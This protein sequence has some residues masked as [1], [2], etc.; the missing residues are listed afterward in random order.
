M[1]CGSL[2]GLLALA[3]NRV[4]RRLR[5]PATAAALFLVLA[6]A[7]VTGVAY[8]AITAVQGNDAGANAIAQTI[9]AN[10]L[11]VSGSFFLVPTQEPGPNGVADE[12]LGGFPTEG[13]TFGILTTG[14][15]TLADD[16]NNAPNS[17]VSLGGGSRTETG[18][19]RDVTILKLDFT[20][21]EGSNCVGFDFKFLSEEYPEFVGV[22]F[23]DAFIAELDVSNWSTEGSQ[24]TAP[25]NFAFDPAGNPITVNATGS[26]SVSPANA[27]G[28]TYDAATA[29]LRAS[30]QLTPGPHSLFLSIFDQGDDVFDSAVF[31]DNLV[32]GFVP[33]PETE[34][35]AGAQQ[36]A[37]ATIE[38]TSDQDTVIAG[39]Q[40]VPVSGISLSELTAPGDG[41]AQSTPLDG[42]PLDGIDLALSPLDGIPL[43]GIGL[44]PQL[45]QQVLG[46]VHLS[47]I[48]LSTAGGWDAVL[49]GTSLDGVPLNT[50]TLADVYALANPPTNDIS[51]GEID[52]SATPLD[53]IPLAGL[54]L[55]PRLLSE[56]PLD[57]SGPNDAAENLADWCEQMNAEPGHPCSAPS[58]LQ[59]E[60]LIGATVK[61]LPLDGIPLDGIPLDGIPLDGIPLDGIPLDGIDLTGT[62][63]DGIP[64][65]GIDFAVSPLDG[66]PLD[67]I[68]ITGSPLDGIPLDGISPATRD[69]VVDCTSPGF[70][71]SGKTLGQAKVAGR[72]LPGANLGML[73]GAFGN[74]TLGELIDALLGSFGLS[75]ADL[76]KGLPEPPERTLHDLLAVLL[77]TAGYDWSDLDL[78]A[79]PIALHSP[80][81]G[82]ISYRATFE[83]TGGASPTVATI[84]ASLPEGGLYG[85][86]STRLIVVGSETSVPLGEPTVGAS[87]L[88]WTP[89][90]DEGTQYELSWQVHA[91]IELGNY[92]ISA[93]VFVTGM[94]A[95]EGSD[96]VSVDVTQ[97]LEPNNTPGVG[98][99]L[100][101]NTLYLSYMLQGDVDRYVVPIP[102]EFGSRVKITLSHITEGTDLDLTVSGPPASVL[103]AAPANSIPLQNTQL[104]DAKVELDE[105]SQALAPE[106]LQDVPTDAITTGPNVVRASSDNRGSADE[107][108]TLISQGESGQYI[109]QVS[110]YQ[111]DS[112]LP[113]MLE[114][115]VSGP[116]NLGNCA[117]RSFPNAGQGAAGAIPNVPA[118]VNTLILV[119]RKRLGDT[120]GAAA[121]NDVMAKLNEL[122][123]RADLGIVGAV[124]PVD[125]DPGVAAAYNAWDANPCSPETANGVVREIGQLIDT[126]EPA[127]LRYKVI[128]GGDDQIPFARVP[129]ETLIANESSYVE[130]LTGP[131]NQYKGAFGY[132][133]LMTDDVYAEEAAP[134]LFGHELFVPEQAVGRVLETPGEITGMIDAFLGADGAA[135]PQRSLVTGYDFLTDGSNAVNAPFATAFGAN[136]QTLINESW[137]AKDPASGDIANDLEDALFPP[138]NAPQLNSINAHFDHT[139]L[140]PAAENAANLSAN[141]YVSQDV[142]DRGAAAVAERV[143]FSMGCHSGLSI[144]DV[145][146]GNGDPLAKDWAQT[147]LAGGA[148][149]WIGNTGYGLGD[150]VEVAYTERLHALFSGN[151]DGSLTLGE[152]LA[153]AKQEY[154]SQL[155]IIGGYD[156]KVVMQATLFGLP[157]LK[158]GTGEPP[159]DPEPLPTQTDPA[160]GLEAAPFNVNPTFTLVNTPDGRFYR[161]QTTQTTNRRP[162]EPAL[163]FDVTQPGKVAH[164]IV[165]T[166]LQS[167]ADEENFDAAFSRVVTDKSED[168]PELVGE[169][170]YP[171]KIQSL[172][173]FSSFASPSVTR[174]NA[175]LIAGL[176]R[177]DGVPDPLGVGTHRLYNQIGG[178][179]LY[180]A[181]GETDFTAP[182]LGPLETLTI[183][184][185]VGFA[186]SV[187]DAAGTVEDVKVIY[188]DCVGTW[189]LSTLQPS[190]ENR[191]S[192]G[193]AIAPSGCNQID[194]YL[195][196]VDDAGNVAVSS[197]KVQI[198]PVVLPPPTGE[199][200]IDISLSGSSHPSG[201]HTGPVSVTITATPAS[202]VEFSLDGAAFQTYAGAFTVGGDGVHIVEARAEDGSTATAGFAIDT[203]APVVLMTTPPAGAVYE[204]GQVVKAEFTC[205]DAGSGPASCTGTVANGAPLATGTVGTKTI[206]VTATDVVGRTFTLTRT[207]QVVYAF[208]GFFD[209]VMNPPALNVQ[210]AGSVIPMKFSLGGN[211]G[212]NIFA[213][214]FPRSQQINCTTKALMG[215]PASTVAQPPG[216][217]YIASSDSYEYLWKTDAK[218]KGT[219]RAFLLGLKDG[220]S[221]RADFRLN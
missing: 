93:N 201:W 199:T 65:D 74:I 75:L 110:D 136:A 154:L 37:S 98:P 58:S 33:N 103:R 190:G 130:T 90:V 150:T 8:A 54:A 204:L 203:T 78:K 113:Y 11:E 188:R 155:G 39:A 23:N 71:C 192:G 45:L 73:D 147:F 145:I 112:A 127:D 109:V 77:G 97:T 216:L 205:A 19:D 42:I 119:N 115:E 82:V 70:D 208:Q 161:A 153:Q 206:S 139:R 86:E 171:A 187:T 178:H 165:I 180:A 218:W 53:G 100:K 162:I 102:S 211:Q 96:P 89:E 88:E 124:V 60:T 184:S 36:A 105:R 29:V 219:C 80:D 21:P 16:P 164:G 84:H 32:V 172:S 129:D 151:L 213:N 24:I 57:Q 17:G 111:G 69:Q 79:F 81:G 52:L 51:L 104:S 186:V 91:P 46:G 193:G 12:P 27:A 200:E 143:L 18:S 144:S 44:T 194:Y 38:L 62:P 25:N 101:A 68:D 117:P 56:I 128:V 183:G 72:L 166:S 209:P 14:D 116:P 5:L 61:G 34:C 123:G 179:V 121:M 67:G 31:L 197:K 107:E 120:Y 3:V 66:I 76:A 1:F 87:Q 30:K 210:N 59:G 157:M 92:A 6:V 217:K 182:E 13:S 142:R 168:E 9:R 202:D 140:L 134:Q 207:Y 10:E 20:A 40:S 7:G 158:V 221:R 163:S 2:R 126:L 138:S 63:L 43:D 175:V 148:F 149:G 214:G 55:G 41:T 198:E 22:A 137:V 177:S 125:G 196:A 185:G 170:A 131:N 135:A 141:L 15:A 85:P 181:P 176:Y 169:A 215:K 64:L 114:V 191:W 132:G 159:A 133:F 146:Y 26:T 173:T 48:P 156:A 47:D 4:A 167:V 28:T 106:T 118:N 50:V 99:E 152:A 108:V 195:Q 83:V 212:L 35:V 189:R 94:E 174:Q 49:A 122:A 220:T 95:P 160:T